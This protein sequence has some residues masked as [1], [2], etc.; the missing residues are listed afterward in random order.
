MQ[1]NKGQRKNKGKRVIVDLQIPVFPT[2]KYA[3]TCRNMMRGDGNSL[4]GGL[5]PQGRDHTRLATLEHANVFYLLTSVS[6]TCPVDNV[7]LIPAVM[8]A[9]WHFL[10]ILPHPS[11]APQSAWTINNNALAGE[12]GSVDDGHDRNNLN[13]PV[14]VLDPNGL[15]VGKQFVYTVIE[16]YPRCW[17]WCLLGD[18]Y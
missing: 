3:P 9:L 13:V 4:S 5:P 7:I 10:A 17:D 12:A 2:L 6:P 16:L 14:S 8:V 11:H 1:Y 15:K 18:N